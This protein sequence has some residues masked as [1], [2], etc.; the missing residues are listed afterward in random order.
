MG[1]PDFGLDG[2]P[3]GYYRNV[4]VINSKDTHKN[5]RDFG[6]AKLAVNA[7]I[8]QSGYNEAVTSAIQSLLSE[9]RDRLGI[10]SLAPNL[11]LII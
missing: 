11:S 3:A 10:K 5:V 4:F 7:K 8:S 6:D 2:S 9:E 1:T